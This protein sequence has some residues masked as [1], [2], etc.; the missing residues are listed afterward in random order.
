M[1]VEVND[2]GQSMDVRVIV[3]TSIVRSDLSSWY[4]D[5]SVS[6]VESCG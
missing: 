4:S 5:V 3:E 6:M 2:L 1:L